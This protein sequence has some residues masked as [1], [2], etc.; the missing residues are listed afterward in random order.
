MKKWLLAIFTCL[1]LAACSDDETQ[2]AEDLQKTIEE[3]TVG[4][5]IVDGKVESATDVPPVVEKEIM[6]ALDEYISSF[7]DKDLNRFKKTVSQEDATYYAET[8]KE[9]EAV[10]TQFSTIERQTEDVTISKYSESRVEVFM[11][12]KGRVVEAASD[13]EMAASAR[14]IIVMIKEEGTW[15][16]AS[17]HSI[18][19]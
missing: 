19:I 12:V 8:M 6:T 5:E 3:G 11:H 4:Y 1:L 15:K 7:N 18:N 16:V 2:S 9:A 10:F 14:Q 13:T 17:V